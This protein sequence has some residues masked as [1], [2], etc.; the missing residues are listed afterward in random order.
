MRKTKKLTA[1]WGGGAKGCKLVV[2][3][4]ADKNIGAV[5]NKVVQGRHNLW[6]VL[7]VVVVDALQFKGSTGS[8]S[9][10]VGEL[11]HFDHTFKSPHGRS[12]LLPHR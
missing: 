10:W 8:V 2:L 5:C 12:W 1:H 4:H 3:T 11:P 7:N 9:K 6:K